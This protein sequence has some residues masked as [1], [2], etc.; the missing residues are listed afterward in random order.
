LHGKFFWRQLSPVGK[1]L[2][3][4]SYVSNHEIHVALNKIIININIKYV[5]YLD[6]KFGQEEE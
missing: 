3:N 1:P 2:Q 4:K 6:T 5:N